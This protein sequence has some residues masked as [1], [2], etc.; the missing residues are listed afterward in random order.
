[1][2]IR[3]KI[4]DLIKEKGELSGSEIARILGVSRQAVNKY[5]LKLV[6]SG[7]VKKTGSTRSTKYSISNAAPQKP[8]RV[9]KF[10]KL[11]LIAEDEVFEEISLF[12]N[13]RKELSENA[14]KIFHYSF[15]E[16]LNNAIEHSESDRCKITVEIDPI[17]ALF[18]VRDFGIGIFYSIASKFDLKDESESVL[19]LAK[20]K[21]TTVMERHTGEGVFFA[22]KLGDFL[23][24][25]SHK[26]ILTFD[27]N[28]RDTFFSSSRYLKGTEVYFSIKKYSKRKISGVFNQYAPE[29]FDY[30]FARTKVLIKLLQSEYV[31]RS[32]A[33][34]LLVGLDKFRE[35]ILDF[36]GVKNIGQGFADEVFRIFKLQHPWINIK[37]IN[38]APALKKI[39]KH[40]S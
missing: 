37:I 30:K 21:R 40:V 12:L 1:M 27:N 31:S 23:T 29:E 4:I 15:T 8:L 20:G 13:L 10:L 18:T 35:I 34:R 28:K 9:E 25:R 24:F 14:F 38:L 6:K 5:V 33:K 3:Q 36:K 39:I 26:I 11:G 19:E 22:S 17:N 16:M 2:N 32:E 7:V